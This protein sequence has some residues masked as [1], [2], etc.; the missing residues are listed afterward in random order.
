MKL[1]AIARVA[2]D[3]PTLGRRYAIKDIRPRIK[4]HRQ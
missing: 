3:F 2:D 1:Y 4:A